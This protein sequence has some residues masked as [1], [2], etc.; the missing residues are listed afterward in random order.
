MVQTRTALIH[1]ADF[2]VVI[3]RIKKDVLQTVEDA[4]NNLAAAVME[5]GGQR[6]PLLIDIR[7]ALPLED[8][9][10]RQYSGQMVI[11]HFSA[12]GLLVDDGPFGRMMGNL[13]FR[14]ADLGI[15]TRLFD[16]EGDA[17]AWLL[18]HRD[19]GP[20]AQDERPGT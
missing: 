10:R 4:T 6:R 17:V 9:I 20:T 14:V 12:L 2:G 16:S 8:E 5:T 15:A 7:A 1:L 18:E 3:A 19:G 11:D 13:Y